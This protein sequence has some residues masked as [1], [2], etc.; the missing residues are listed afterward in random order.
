MCLFCVDGLKGF[1]EAAYPQ[2]QA[3]RCIIHQIRSP[4]S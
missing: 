3:Q 2:S 4:A 1:V